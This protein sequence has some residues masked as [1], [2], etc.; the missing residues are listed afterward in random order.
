MAHLPLDRLGLNHDRAA[1]LVHLHHPTGL[2]VLPAALPVVAGEPDEIPDPQLPLLLLVDL[3]LLHSPGLPV[4]P[5]KV[6]QAQREHELRCAVRAPDTETLQ[7]WV[8]NAYRQCLGRDPESQAAIDGWADHAASVGYDAMKHAICFSPEGR[9]H[10]VV[11]A[12]RECLGRDPESQAAID[13]WTGYAAAN[14]YASLRN[15]I[16]FS[17][18][19]RSY[20]VAKAYRQCL[21]REPERPS[22]GRHL[23]EPRRFR[24][25][26]SDDPRHLQ[27]PRG[28]GPPGLLIGALASADLAQTKAQTNHPMLPARAQSPDLPPSPNPQSPTDVLRGTPRDFARPFLRYG[29]PNAGPW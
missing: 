15:G 20:N 9:S 6:Q 25:L 19:G 1:S 16:C 8:K 22:G 4:H 3:D 13:G 23:V 18:E 17:P 2:P 7:A 11:K 28:P 26:P 5:D 27:Q 14:G 10:N 29:H 21:G 24:R 12:Y